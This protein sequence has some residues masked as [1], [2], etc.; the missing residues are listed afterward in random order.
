M[1][2]EDLSTLCVVD[3]LYIYIYIYILHVVHFS[4]IEESRWCGE[5]SKEK[6]VD[7]IYQKC[8]YV[9]ILLHFRHFMMRLCRFYFY[10]ILAKSDIRANFLDEINKQFN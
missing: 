3:H 1:R 8:R 7:E 5:G 9:Y 10:R 2:F 6:F 4:K